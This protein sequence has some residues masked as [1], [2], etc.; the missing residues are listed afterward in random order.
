PLSFFLLAVNYRNVATLVVGALPLVLV[1]GAVEMFPKSY[2]TSFESVANPIV[3]WSDGVSVANNGYFTMLLY[4]E[5]QRKISL[6]L[7]E[8]FHNRQA[9][10]QQAQQRASLIAAQSNQ[11]NVHLVV[12]ES[13]LDP[14]LFTKARYTGNPV[15]PAF[16][17]LFGSN[18]GFSI[19]PVFGGGTAQA[20]FEVLCGVPAFRELAGVE[21]N[22]FSGSPA[23]CTPGLLGLAGYRTIASNA[24]KPNFFNAIPAYQGIGFSEIYFPQEYVATGESYLSTGDLTGEDYMFD[25]TLFSQNLAFIAKQLQEEKRRPILNYLLS[26]YGH[27]PHLMNEKIRP[28]RFELI[29]KHDDEQLERSANQYYYRTQ[30]IAEYVNNLI[31]LDKNSLIIIVSDHVPPLQFGPN[32]YRDLS[33]LDNREGSYYHNRLMIIEDGVVKKYAKMHHYDIQKVVFNYITQGAYCRENG[34]DFLQNRFNPDRSALRERY[35][36]LMAHATE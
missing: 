32:T 36:T 28:T 15:H 4:R 12:M 26:M 11:R 34:C 25:G 24:F 30:A 31:K 14:T 21:F 13:L 35:F 9:Y 7:T 23:Y 33:Y 16:T 20:E 27:M 19:S 5:A 8:S 10:D 17:K 3:S 22:Q 18:L 6:Q 29:A 1:I 2:A